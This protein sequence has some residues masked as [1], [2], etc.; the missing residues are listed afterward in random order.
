M[1]TDGFP[2]LVR[3]DNLEAEWST[4]SPALADRPQKLTIAYSTDDF[5]LEWESE[6]APRDNSPAA[7]QQWLR[8]FAETLLPPLEGMARVP[9]SPPLDCGDVVR[10][11]YRCVDR[12]ARRGWTKPPLE[13][14]HTDEMTPHTALLEVRK[15]RQWAA[16][17][18]PTSD[19]GGKQSEGTGATEPP[20]AITKT[21]QRKPKPSELLAYSQWQDAVK[22]NAE[23]DGAGDGTVY[24]WLAENT[25]AGLPRR[26][27]WQRYVRTVRRAAG[28]QKH[29]P[30]AGREHGNSVARPDEI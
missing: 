7:A 2:L 21:A 22:Q 1:S 15:L 16:D 6:V 3:R 27:T 23:L 9:G 24:D 14:E 28:K 30:R 5:P 8:Y 10:D 29:R 26:D 25:D 19:Q 11:A 20:K 4:A 12:L 13:P 17:H 18:R